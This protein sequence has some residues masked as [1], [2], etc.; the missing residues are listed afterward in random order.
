MLRSL[1]NNDNASNNIK[2]GVDT[3]VETVERFQGGQQS[4][5]VASGTVSDPQFIRSENEFLLQQNRAN[6]SFTR[7][8]NK[9]VVIA[10][11]SLLSHIPSD[12]DVY[13][14]AI[15]WK[16]LPIE[17]GSS[18]LA[19][20]SPEWTGDLTEFAAP[21]NPPSSLTSQPIEI[22]IYTL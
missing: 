14:E 7:H 17:V 16:Q 5:M 13:D 12:P 22:N 18:P 10:A 3:H 1:E 8:E 20:S 2:L 11:E 21:I 6:V 19:G 4:L 15:L 9:L